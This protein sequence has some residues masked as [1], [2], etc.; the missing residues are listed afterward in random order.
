MA[1]GL[2]GAPRIWEGLIRRRAARRCHFRVIF[3]PIWKCTFVGVAGGCSV[4]VN[5]ISFEVLP[6]EIFFLWF[7]VGIGGRPLFMQAAGG[8]EGSGT[9]ADAGCS[10]HPRTCSDDLAGPWRSAV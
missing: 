2:E 4:A 5:P 6:Y 10:S 9:D 1:P 3:R 8:A 7:G